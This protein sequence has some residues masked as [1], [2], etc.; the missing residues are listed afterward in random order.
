MINSWIVLMPTVIVL[1]VAFITKKV[2]PALFI[3]I[4]IAAF[5]VADFAPLETIRI[6]FYNVIEQF[7][8]SNIY[9]FSFLIILGS[10]ITMM[11]HTGG[12]AAYAKLIKKRLHTTKKVEMASLCLSI[13]FAIDEYFS[14]LTVGSIMKSITDSF[15][16]PRA[17][18]AFFLQSLGSPLLILI[19]ISTWIAMLL[20]QLE[21]AGVSLH[22]AD[23]PLILADPFAIYLQIIPFIFYSII[24]IFSLFFIVQVPISFGPMRKQELIA[25]E[26]GN[27][28]GGKTPLPETTL[29]EQQEGS[30]FDFIMP[31]GS[32][33]ISIFLSILYLGNS[34]WL[35]GTNSL[36]AT[37]QTVNIFLALLVGVIIAF[38]SSFSI[39]FITN[40]ITLHALP[41][42][43]KEGLNLMKDSIAILLLAW[44]FSSLLKNDLKAG[45]YIAHLI[46]GSINAGFLPVMFFV[47]A[48]VTSA[49]TGSAW[50]TIAVLVPLAIPMLTAFFNLAIPAS[51]EHVSLLFPVIG[52]IFAGSVAGE[53]VSP[54]GTTT[55]MAAAS[56]GCYLHD[57]VITQFPYA[58]PALIATA[59][60][61]IVAGFSISYGL[62]ISSILSL[63]IGTL[64][65]MAMLFLFNY[66]YR[67]T[68]IS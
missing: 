11:S 12:T 43:F 39:F 53:H 3:G 19:P 1:A 64:L 25:H 31:I 20:M 36:I 26:S 17:K 18:L 56:A 4:V 41:M 21:K 66:W 34:S 29:H 51:P 52:A 68:K 5:I 13:C 33:F 46:I 45:E 14:I 28:F 2:L 38:I 58:L 42:L 61:Y 49:G 27:L 35:G 32:L 22:S 59:I 62:L 6:V 7:D 60:A 15:K 30:L 63:T 37:I 23:K 48:L 8:S 9:M 55:V 44:T 16:I 65:T 10:L 57:H 67:D 47:T 50:G 54:I 24:I 40:K